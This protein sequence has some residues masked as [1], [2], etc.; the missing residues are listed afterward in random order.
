MKFMIVTDTFPP[1]INGVARTL[2]TLARG[3]AGR[4]HA[5]HV[6]TTNEGAECD[7]GPVSLKRVRSFAI[8]GYAEV[9]LGLPS[10]GTL[11]EEIQE[12]QP[13]A[14]YVAVETPMGVSAIR[15]AHAAGVGVVSGFHTNFH[16]YATD[17]QVPILGRAMAT[18]LRWVHNR[19]HRTLTP[20][21]GMADALR[22]MG[23]RNVGVMGR[24]VDSELFTPTRRDAALRAEWGAGDDTPVA[25][26]VSRIAAEKNLPLA[27]RAFQRLQEVRPGTR[28]VFVGD[29]PKLAGLKEEHP[30]FIYVGAKTGADL[31]RH[32]ASADVFVFPSLTETFGNVVTEALA[33]G[34]VTVA[35]D[36]AAAR[37]CIRHGENGFVAP[38]RD[39]AA[40]VASAEQG[41]ARWN[42]SAL[43]QA[44]FET[45]RALSWNAIIEQFE[46]ELLQAREALLS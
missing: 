41:L 12:N 27:V 23:I 3:L 44:A 31:G 30:E 4:G 24:G 43:R 10:R 21:E 8:P 32:F 29:G 19:T 18:Y 6:V 15:A 22:E 35:F 14:M 39:E 13:D 2:Q 37:Q 17:Y 1:D 42:D 46:R 5:V 11:A 38:L 25:L 40:F 45:G 20:S 26:F 9:R 28:C 36:Y 33:S 34:L 7:A 16:T